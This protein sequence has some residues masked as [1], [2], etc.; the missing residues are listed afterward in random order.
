MYWCNVD[1]IYKIIVRHSLL[2]INKLAICKDRYQIGYTTGDL[3]PKIFLF[4]NSSKLLL[5]IIYNKVG[6]VSSN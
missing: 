6:N 5:M 3:Y 2:F 1:I 4:S